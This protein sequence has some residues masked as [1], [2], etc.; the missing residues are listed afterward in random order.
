MLSQWMVV[1]P[2]C[3]KP[4]NF[5]RDRSQ[6]A[7]FA[8]WQLAMYSASVLDVATVGCFL[9]LQEIMPVPRLKA[10]LDVERRVS[11]QAP[12]SESTHPVRETSRLPST[13]VLCRVA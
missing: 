6:T 5:N 10:Y 11:V 1:A 8:P 13:S 4:R 9:E 12:Q 7:S 3:A 2:S